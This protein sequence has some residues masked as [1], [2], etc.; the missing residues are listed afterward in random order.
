MMLAQVDTETTEG[1]STLATYQ[2]PNKDWK[3]ANTQKLSMFAWKWRLC[4]I[5]LL[6]I[7]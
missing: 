5:R 4:M 1:Q 7:A 3:W 2:T 6:S